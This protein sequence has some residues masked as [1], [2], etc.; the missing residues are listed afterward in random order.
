MHANII[1]RDFFTILEGMQYQIMAIDL[2]ASDDWN[3]FI[4]R[5][6]AYPD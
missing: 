2:A 6:T 4:P 3:L 1:E 5:G